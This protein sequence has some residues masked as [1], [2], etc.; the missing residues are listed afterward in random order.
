[1]VG[2]HRQPHVVVAEL[3]GEF[4]RAEELLVLPAGR[5]V[6]GG[7]AGEP[8]RYFEQGV[9]VV[10]DFIAGAPAQHLL[11]VDAVVPV[12]LEDEILAR[13]QG[14]R[15]VDAHHR[16]VDHVL[17]RLAIGARQAADMEAALEVAAREDAA[18]AFE[19]HR[20]VARRPGPCLA[21]GR[22]GHAARVGIGLVDILVQLHP[23]V[24]ERV[25]RLVVISDGAA[26]GDLAPG[27]IERG[28][29]RVVGALLPVGV[30]RRAGGGAV[31]I[32]GGQH[33]FELAEL[34]VEWFGGEGRHGKAQ[35]QRSDGA[36]RYA[37]DHPDVVVRK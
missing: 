9:L 19:L 26:A 23:Q 20:V 31:G 34:V 25:G 2:G 8:L 28:A 16:A 18:Q 3:Q 30:A 4:A 7:H 6:I 21:R 15:Q 27:F 10:E 35:S 37:H 24:A 14:L 22:R 12:D 17:Q 29:D 36:E 32:R 11:F 5:V 33:F 1:M 13:F